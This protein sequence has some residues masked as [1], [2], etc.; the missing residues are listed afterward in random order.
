MKK[1]ICIFMISGMLAFF[2]CSGGGSEGDQN[3]EVEA[4][5]WD[6]LATPVTADGHVIEAPLVDFLPDGRMVVADGNSAT[7]IE[8]AIETANGS[9][10]FKYVTSIIPETSNSFGSFIRAVD[11]DSVIL[12]ASTHIYRI[13]P[14]TGEHSILAAASNF[15]AALSGS[16]LYFT[17]SSYNP[18]FSASSHVSFLD[19]NSPGTIT[20]VISGIPGASAGVCL[21]DKGSIY[22]GNGYSNSGIL[23]ETGLI[24]RFALSAL[25][26]VWSSGEDIARV[27][28]ATPLLY[29]GNDIILTGG[30]DIFGTGDANYFAA[31]D[32]STG[33]VIFRLDPDP[34]ADSYYKLSAGNGRFAASIWDY[35]GRTGT[36]YLLPFEALGL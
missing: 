25:P 3:A 4:I 19:I 21:D 29:A 23:N 18:D 28:S 22:T 5:K 13:N 32:A 10:A 12:G 20:E 33:E 17:W 6:A 26:Q 9:R 1:L 30:G 24:R 8:V 16:T 34:S 36:L 2:G 31:F 11:A 7:E 27:L 15:D 35:S 14:E